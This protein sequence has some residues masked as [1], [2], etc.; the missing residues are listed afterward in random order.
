MIEVAMVFDKQGRVIHWHE[1]RG[2]HGGAIPDSRD[3]WSV[4]WENRERL[5]GV[6]HTHPWNGEPWPSTTD[7]T[8]WRAVEQALGVLLVWPVV[9]FDQVGYWVFNRVTEEY[10]PVNPEYLTFTLEGLDELR[11]KSGHKG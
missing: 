6:A 8:T 1:P 10:T 5:A 9:T 7:T 4:I 3:L 11:R 2:A